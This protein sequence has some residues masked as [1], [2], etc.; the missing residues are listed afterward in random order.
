MLCIFFLNPTYILCI[1][2]NHIFKKQVKFISTSVT[3]L[4]PFEILEYKLSYVYPFFFA[5]ILRFKTSFLHLHVSIQRQQ[6]STRVTFNTAEHSVA[7]NFIISHY[8]NVM[9]YL[10]Y[11]F[12]IY[13]CIYSYKSYMH[14]TPEIILMTFS[15]LLWCVVGTC[16]L[17]KNDNYQLSFKP[18]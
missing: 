8:Y 7:Y 15:V 9:I 5:Y 13:L 2:E 4:K 3:I 1:F 12:G 16:E 11:N 18:F 14:I 6:T 17:L 10:Y